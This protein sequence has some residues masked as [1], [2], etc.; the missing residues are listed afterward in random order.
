[1]I[2]FTWSDEHKAVRE[3]VRDFCQKEIAPNLVERDRAQK[4][5]PNVL[6]KLAEKDILGICIPAKYGGA[7]FDYISL[8]VCCEELEYCDTS[9]RVIM[10]VHVGLNSL[11]LFSW[12]AG[13][14]KKKDLFPT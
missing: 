8:G 4:F 7:G 10:S 6:K 2:D 14:P 5:D 3:L 9:L 12:G 1:M 11:T 13:E